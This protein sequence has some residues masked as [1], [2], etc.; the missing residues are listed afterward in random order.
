MANKVPKI[1]VLF[2]NIPI[3]N[4]AAPW[5]GKHIKFL[6]FLIFL[7]D[8]SSMVFL[9]FALKFFPLILIINHALYK[10]HFF[11]LKLN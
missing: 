3:L 7:G 6:I 5:L 8:K 10:I 11:L 2:K 4:G 1:C 9:D